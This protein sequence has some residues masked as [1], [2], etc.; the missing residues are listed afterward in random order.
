MSTN[1]KGGWINP[2][3]SMFW[4]TSRIDAANEMN[5]MRRNRNKRVRPFVHFSFL[6]KFLKFSIMPS[7]QNYIF[8][9]PY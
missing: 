9:T 5:G 2:T 7:I 4:L 8:N 1:W 3:L 6:K